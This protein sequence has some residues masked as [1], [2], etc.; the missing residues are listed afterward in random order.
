METNSFSKPLSSASGTSSF[1]ST[2][3]RLRFG[4]GAAGPGVGEPQLSGGKSGRHEKAVQERPG[5]PAPYLDLAEGL[6]RQYQT[7]GAGKLE[8][9]V[10]AAKQAR[11]LWPDGMEVEFWEGASRWLLGQ[12]AEARQCLQRFIEHPAAVDDD[13]IVGWWR[14]HGS[15]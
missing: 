8:E 4:V 12:V 1:N 11:K 3:T 2:C 9:A 7:S 15:C 5:D 13:D 10:W 14:K 6:V